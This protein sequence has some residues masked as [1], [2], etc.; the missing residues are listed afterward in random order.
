MSGDSFRVA[1]AEWP[2]DQA[3]IRA[4]REAVFVH[5]LGVPAALE[6]DG[7]DAE[8]VQVLARDPTG[9]PV[10]TGRLAADGKIGRMAVLADWRG[11]GVGSALLV[12]LLEAARARGDTA[13]YLHAQVHALPFYRRHGFEAWGERFE[14]EGIPHLAMRRAL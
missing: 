3:A 9:V 5:E 2:G 8:C 4:V 12:A 6:W 7:L 1:T 11:H 14:E 13:V 10:G